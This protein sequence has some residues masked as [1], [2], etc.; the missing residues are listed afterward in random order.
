M[1]GYRKAATEEVPEPTPQS[2]VGASGKLPSA[3]DFIQVDAGWREVKA[4]DGIIQTL[5][6]QLPEQTRLTAFQSL[7]VLQAASIDRQGL[8]ALIIP[9]MDSAGREYPFLVF[10]RVTD[11]EFSYKPDA[12]FVSAMDRLSD[13][14]EAP[15]M[16]S[17][18]RQSLDVSMLSDLNRS[19]SYCDVRIAR[20]QAMQMVET[21]RLQAFLQPLA[22]DDETSQRKALSGLIALLEVLKTR[23]LHR[24]YQ[25]I[26]LPL[27]SGVTTAKSLAFWM[28]L[29]SAVIN[30][31]SW[32]PDVFWID[33]EQDCR[34]FILTKPLTATAMELALHSADMNTQFLGWTDMAREALVTDSHQMMASHWLGRKEA[35]LL[36]LMIDWY[37]KF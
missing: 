32:C 26:W 34:C 14:I 33:T 31:K 9:S 25:G 12:L 7:G 3:A 29:L 4:L 10:N 6:F 19:L 23:R 20:R 1:F 24:V 16:L 35:N 13:L 2:L 5:Y 27:P 28:Q 22:G 11:P 36:D 30:D 17:I 18:E 21:I 15:E 37:Q 8:L